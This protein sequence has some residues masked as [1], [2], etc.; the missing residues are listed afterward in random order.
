[1]RKTEILE[2]HILNYIIF[3]L[4]AWVAQIAKAILFFLQLES[5]ILFIGFYTKYTRIK[6]WLLHGTE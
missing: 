5:T 4:E 2:I 6:R 1:M 3:F